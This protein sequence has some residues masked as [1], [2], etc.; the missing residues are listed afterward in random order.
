MET[1][2]APVP[3]PEVGPDM[4]V[5]VPVWLAGACD[6]TAVFNALEG[7]TV[8][9]DSPSHTVREHPDRGVRVAFLPEPT[10]G[11]DRDV[12]WEV[13]AYADPGTE[14]ELW[15]ASFDDQTPPETIAAFIAA[16]TDPAG[17]VRRLD[18]LPR[19][20]RR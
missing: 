18:E 19:H 4:E 6:T 7:W 17:A 3:Q 10:G 5:T 15:R 2:P 16:A 1:I 13:A 12:V 14:C 11:A 20:P 9:D 8:V